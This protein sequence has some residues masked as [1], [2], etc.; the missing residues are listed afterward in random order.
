MRRPLV[1][2]LILLA[3]CAESAPAG[4][5]AG[6]GLDGA[7]G[8]DA[9]LD[10]GQDPDAGPAPLAC[11]ASFGEATACGG[12][13]VGEW[14]Y[15]EVCGA[16]KQIGDFLASCPAA[17]VVRNQHTVTGTAGF[18]PNASFGWRLS[19]DFDVAIEVPVACTDSLGGC[20]GFALV[21]GIGLGQAVTCD[22]RDVFCDCS[23]A[24]NKSERAMGRYAGAG[25][26]LTTTRSDGKARD[27][28]YCVDGD[29]ALYRRTDDAIVF[30]LG[31]R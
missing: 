15:L 16:P 7:T 29:R 14:D 2:I 30:L 9:A 20:G 4:G 26:T 6:A 13:L 3:S 18:A 19:D 17:R 1:P 27:Y 22:E 23:T 25:G 31:R 10:A 28:Y 21:V 5:D 11:A 24:G 8:A 12:D